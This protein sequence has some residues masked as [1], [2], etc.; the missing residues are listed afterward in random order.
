[1]PTVLITGGSGLIGQ[2]LTS[3]LISKGYEV[4]I[5]S[6][7][8]HTDIQKPQISY[9]VWNI[10][11]QQIDITA[12]VKADYIIHLAGAG[13]MDKRWTKK[14][15]EQIVGSRTKSSQLLIKALKENTNKVK[16][17][18]S[19]SAIG[20]Y[21]QN[22]FRSLSGG[23]EFT[24]SDKAN[25]DFLGNTC[26][27][28]EESIEPVTSIGKRLVKL[29]LGIVLSNNGGAFVEFKKPM[30][31][32]IAGILGNGKQIISWVH[33]DDICRMFIYAIENENLSG[34]YNAVS[35]EPVSN[36][37][38]IIRTAELLRKTFYIPVYVPKFF[39][40]LILGER[41]IEVLKNATVS[42]KKIKSEGFTFLYPSIDAALRQLTSPS[43][44]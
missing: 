40:K 8:L 44:P 23:E 1:M 26:R 9:A 7:K 12:V 43:A 38:L 32:G 30:R 5:L 41:S 36:K 19:A 22:R 2:N 21:G 18:V 16:A 35:P 14:Y 29:R 24:E 42:C 3:H 37:E 31:F 17:V 4:I 27:I 6:R 10:E 15:K 11:E 25:T 28:W 33:I 13:V 20:W 34:S 39:L